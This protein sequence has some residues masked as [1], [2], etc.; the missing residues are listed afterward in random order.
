MYS[1]RSLMRL[2]RVQ[3][4]LPVHD[5]LAPALFTPARRC[6]STTVAKKAAASAP[7]Q[8]AQ[9]PKRKPLTKEQRDFLDSAVS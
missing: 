2:M 6:L 8:D 7:A 1:S 9:Q 4:Q 5:F 3:G